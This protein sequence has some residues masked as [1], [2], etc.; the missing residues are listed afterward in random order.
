MA[1]FNCLQRDAQ[2]AQLKA[3]EYPK[4]AIPVRIQVRHPCH[5]G[6]HLRERPLRALH[7]VEVVGHLEAIERQVHA[8]LGLG[9]ARRGF[10]HAGAVV[11]DHRQ[12][13]R[14]IPRAHP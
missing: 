14:R 2:I 5:D 13:S 3:V 8:Q 12:R 4:L 7:V 1:Q 9:L 6:A 10:Q 11:V